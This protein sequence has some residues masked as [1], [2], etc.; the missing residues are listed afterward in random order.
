MTHP[1]ILIVDDESQITRHA[2]H[3][4]LRSTIRCPRCQ[5]RRDRAGDHEGLVARPCR[6]RRLDAEH[7]GLALCREVRMR[8][9]VPIIVLSVK[10]DER[11]KI[12]ALDLGADDYVT[13]PFSSNELLARVRANLRRAPV[14]EESRR[15]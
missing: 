10:E 11:T 15:R 13:K 14:A 2:A 4:A 7:D 8:S 9:Q 12:Q 5:R 3:H 1:R 6:Y